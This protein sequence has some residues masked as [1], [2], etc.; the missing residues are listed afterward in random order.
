V[1]LF[2]VVRANLRQA[3]DSRKPRANRGYQ[4]CTGK[5]I[6][7]SWILSGAYFARRAKRNLRAPTHRARENGY[8]RAIGLPYQLRCN[9]L[10]W[11]AGTHNSPSVEEDHRFAKSCRGREV[12]E[13]YDDG[14]L[15]P[16]VQGSQEV[17]DRDLMVDVEVRVGLVKHED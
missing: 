10:G 1:G 12:V 13:H 15:M 4:V 5:Y 17:E 6:E 7:T 2:E 9:H 8:F 16:A 11:L 14:H 3:H